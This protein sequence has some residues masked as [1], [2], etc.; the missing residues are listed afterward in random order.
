MRLSKSMEYS[1]A[2]SMKVV[3]V[4]KLGALGST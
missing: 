4:L 3:G 1:K 2:S